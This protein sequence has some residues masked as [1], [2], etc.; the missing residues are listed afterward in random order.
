M[1]I[2]VDYFKAVNDTY[3]H[4][5]GDIVLKGVAQIIE[6]E[7][8]AYDTAVRYGGEE[9][10]VVLSKTDL[11]HA[12]DVAERIRSRISE[13]WHKETNI[14]IS[15]GVSCSLEFDRP[16][17]LMTDPSYRDIVTKYK[18][19]LPALIVETGDKR[20]Y[21]AKEGGRNRVVSG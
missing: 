8:R 16:K 17:G 11:G 21:E 18:N 13:E 19:S 2:D 3:G 7:I 10:C 15:I 5:V 12:A 9:F 1:M 14:T 6:Q 4:A 20:L